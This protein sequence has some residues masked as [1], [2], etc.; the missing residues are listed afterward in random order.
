MEDYQTSLQDLNEENK[1]LKNIVSEMTILNDL[2]IAMSSTMEVQEIMAKIITK[3]IKTIGAEQGTIMLVEKNSNVPMRTIIRG[4]NEESQGKI[5]KL[6]SHLVG[7]MINN[8]KPFLVNDTLKDVRLNGLE[9]DSSEIR[10]ILSV[11]MILRGQLIGVINLFNKKEK[12][13]FTEDDQKLVCII[14]TH[15]GSF[16]INAKYFEQVKN[17]KDVLLQ[18]SNRLQKEVGAQYGFDDFIGKSRIIEKIKE[19]LKSIAN[20]PASVL[21]LG[22]TGTGKEL[23]AKI[24]HYNSG[25]KDLPFVDINSAAI[26]ENLVESELFGIEEGV[27]TGVKKRV[28][29]FEQANEGTIFIDEIGDMSLATQAK[30]LRVLEEKQFRRVG[31]NQNIKIDI[32][33]IAATNKN[34]KDEIKNGAFRDDLYYR[35]SVFE[36]DLPPLRER[37]DDIALLLEHFVRKHG[38][39]MGK[40]VNG[41]S[42]DAFEILY[43]YDWPGNVRELANIV[44][45]AVIL[46]KSSIINIEHLPLDL[47]NETCSLLIDDLSFEEAIK[48]FKTGLILKALNKSGNNK[49]EVARNLKISREYFF[50]LLNQLGIREKVS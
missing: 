48:H 17:T 45:R 2:S 3:T 39:R 37:R 44:E 10:S 34:L 27:A 15:V 8:Q 47:K 28:G 4:V 30:I 7:W 29:L 19:E 25:R 35:L 5:Y 42:S 43:N 1:H 9:I 6:G 13:L 50:R 21:I 41:F 26:P 11:P 31:S 12:N 36:I 14:A 23:V 22:E 33:L 40:V 46:T 24:I 38:E 16:L 18:R 20:S 49:A 32:R